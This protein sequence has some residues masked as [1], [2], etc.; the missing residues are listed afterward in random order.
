LQYSLPNRVENGAAGQG[1][2][3]FFAV[4]EPPPAPGSF[5]SIHAGIHLKLVHA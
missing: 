4:F 1:F 5:A 2:M 3:K